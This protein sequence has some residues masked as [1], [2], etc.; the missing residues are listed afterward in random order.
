MPS[1]NGIQSDCEVIAEEL[2][3]KLRL[4]FRKRDAT[5][6]SLAESVDLLL[7]LK[8]PPDSL[9]AEFLSYADNRASDQLEL[10]EDMCENDI[11]EFMDVASSGFLVDL[12]LVVGSYRNMF[13]E[14]AALDENEFSD[15]FEA[16][17]VA[18]LD[19][20][21]LA[22]VNKYFDLVTKRIDR[23][24]DTALLV[25]ALDKFHRKLR[26]INSLCTEKDFA[27]WV[28][29][30]S[31]LDFFFYIIAMQWIFLAEEERES[32]STLA[33]NSVSLISNR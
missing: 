18:R 7:R 14:R 5:T 19:A 27:K 8:E 28:P 4:E 20:F 12:C 1:F 23:V 24:A 26:T 17:A 10:L 13:V 31:I 33:E 9:C 3:A 22:N 29:V 6:K 32:R 11:L 16:K 25:R 15:D 30:I 2:K 21:V